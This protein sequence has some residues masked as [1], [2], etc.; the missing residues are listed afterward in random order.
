MTP[1]TVMDQGTG[2]RP[3]WPPSAWAIS[4]GLWERVRVLLREESLCIILR[5]L[6]GPLHL[7]RPAVI[8]AGRQGAGEQHHGVVIVA[9]H[10]FFRYL[11]VK[12]GLTIAIEKRQASQAIGAIPGIH[13]L[14]EIWR[15]HV[16]DIQ[17][18]AVHCPP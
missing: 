15:K 3:V 8:E 10:G 17:I 4:I 12:E 1:A 7:R 18:Q 13:L 5:P 14:E 6:K 9:A 2:L 11:D 16:L